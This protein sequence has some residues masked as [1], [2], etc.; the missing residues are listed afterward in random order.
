[1]RVAEEIV[2][3]IVEE[4]HKVGAPVVLLFGTALHE[5]RNGTGNCV[6]PYFHEDDFDIGVF[7]EHF[8]YVVLLMDEIKTKFGWYGTKPNADQKDAFIWFGPKGMLKRRGGFQVDVYSF[9]VDKPSKGMVYFPWDQRQMAS[10]SFLPLVKHKPSTD[11]AIAGSVPHYYMPYDTPCFLENLYG[12]DYMTP[13][14]K[15]KMDHVNTTGVDNSL[16]F[17]HPHCNRKM[18]NEDLRE[19]ERQMSFVNVTYP[20]RSKAEAV[21]N[22]LR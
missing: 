10:N 9:E 7:R 16:K 14:R 12:A 13:K 1:M 17:G 20:F 2:K 11:V 19:L 5:H 3:F 22:G 15:F 18:S 4:L 8:H 21:W 6:Q